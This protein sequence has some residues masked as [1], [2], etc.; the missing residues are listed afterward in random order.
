MNA[1]SKRWKI[2]FT[3]RRKPIKR[4]AGYAQQNSN[5]CFCFAHNEESRLRE[6]A[7]FT[8]SQLPSDRGDPMLIRAANGHPGAEI[9]K[10]AVFWL[11]QYDD[12]R[13]RQALMQIIRR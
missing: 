1:P 4:R 6:P 8:I 7:I 9:R 10:K 13:A 11:G 2:F 5:A 3:S 12:E